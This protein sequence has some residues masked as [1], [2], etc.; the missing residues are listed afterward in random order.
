MK[1]TLISVVLLITLFLFSISWGQVDTVTLLH[2]N[3]THSCLAPI[4]P[5]DASLHG[6][7]GGIARVASLVGQLRATNP[8]TLFLHGGDAFIGDLFF[9]TYFGIPELQLLQAL[10]LD[11][12]AVGNHEFD[13]TPVTLLTALDSSFTGGGFPLL[14]A[15]LI[16]EDPTVNPLKNYIHPYTIKQ[17]G[18]VK[19]GIFGLTTPATNTLSQPQP[20]VVDTGFIQTGATMV[21]TLKAK[22]CQVIIC[23]SHLGLTFDE[24][25]AQSVPG[26]HVIIGGHDHYKL[27]HPV[28][29]R[30]PAGETTLI[31][32]ANAFYLNLGKLTLSVSGKNV[33]LLSYQMYDINNSIPEE[34][35]IKN[36]VDQLIAGIEQTYPGVF[37]QRIGYATKD[38]EEVA[39]SLSTDGY[40][41]TP[42]GNLVTAAFR[43]ALGTDIAIEAGGSTAQKLYKGPIVADDLFRVV[44][45]GFN[46]TN[47]LGYELATFKMTGAALLAG[48]EFGLSSLENDEYLMQTSGLDYTY[49]AHRAPGNRVTRA[50]VHGQLLDTNRT[51]TVAANQFVPGFL[52]YLQ[53]PY[54]DLHICNGDTT[55]FQVLANYVSALDTISPE[56]R[57]NIISPVKNSP[58]TAPMEYKLNQ[59][60]PNPFNPS[61][62]IGYQVSTDSHV[63]LKIY[64]MLGRTIA[65]LVDE[66]KPAG[67][68]SI[69][70]NASHVSSGVYF[71]RFE[72]TGK[73]NVHFVETKKL[74]LNK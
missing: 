68:H 31:V 19:V 12:M 32:Q 34:P 57:G 71:Y 9:N 58:F 64:D 72:A 6:S 26:I 60:Y 23:L 36:T 48:L 30:N 28:E 35:T 66:Q 24:L 61:T 55:E 40:K 3:D 2:I 17:A 37:T 67:K 54:S 53:I 74:L 4:G 16:L 52:D 70:W 18:N 59:N 5:R 50:T 49:N 11:A 69:V 25:L 21:D 27:Q 10:G 56:R 46:E 43:A 51:Y 47:G 14:S 73:N 33:R 42:I 20:A 39:D 41:D 62:E 45:Y 65:V 7:L 29:I 44:G 38:F 8:N 15:N 22:G 13:L 1:H 63:M